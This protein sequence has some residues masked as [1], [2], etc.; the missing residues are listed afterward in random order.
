M[1]IYLI[2]IAA[3]DAL[4]RD[5]YNQYALRWM[6]SWGCQATGALAMLSCEV[7]IMLLTFMSVERFVTIV[8]P[9]RPRC[10]THRRGHFSLAFIWLT[11]LLLAV[12]PMFVVDNYYDFYGSN[13][14]CFP[15]HVH[16]EYLP[17][18]QYSAFIFVGLNLCAMLVIA[19]AYVGMFF[20]VLRTRKQANSCLKRDMSFA[21][22]FFLIVL[23]DAL[24]W[25]PVVIIKI[26]ALADIYL[27]GEYHQLERYHANTHSYHCLYTCQVKIIG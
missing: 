23:T 2:I 25:I 11:G 20:S 19:V 9:Y 8:F 5:K 15:L 27:S 7:T 24:C 12:L 13:G 14:V 22:R 10:L 21:K 18:W 17:G 1:G 6:S 16:D 26:L 4:Y 3:H